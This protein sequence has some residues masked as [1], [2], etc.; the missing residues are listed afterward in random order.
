MPFPP[1]EDLLNPGMETASLSIPGFAGRVFTIEPPGSLVVGD[2][3]CL[4]SGPIPGSG[5]SLGEGSPLQYSWLED[6]MGRGAWWATVLRVT[7][8]QTRLK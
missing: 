5:R 7:A 3:F 4:D 2:N 1:P 6:P 8:S